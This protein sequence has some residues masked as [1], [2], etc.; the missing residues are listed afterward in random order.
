MT[1][2]LATGDIDVTYGN[3][4]VG[5]DAS[6]DATV[7]YMAEMAKGKFGARSP[8]IRAAAINIINGIDPLN[9]KRIGVPVDNKDYFGMLEAIHNYVRD[10]IR[11]V[12]DVVGQETL[13]YPEETIFNSRAGDCDDMTI[14]EI[15][16]LGAI[17]LRSYPVVIGL[18]PGH[19]SHV[20]LHAEIPEGRHRNAGKTFAADPI[21]REWELG[22]A[23][24]DARVKAKRVYPHLA[25]LGTMND[26]GAYANGPSYFSP[27]DEL[28]AS[29]V[30]GVLKRRITDT[31]SRGGIITTKR[32]TERGDELDAMFSRSQTISPMQAAPAFELYSRGPTTNRAEKVMTSYLHQA[33]ISALRQPASR[34]P[35]I[36]TVQD[37][38]RPVRKGT[39]APTINELKGLADY[40]NDLAGPAVAAS[41]RH[42][43]NGKSDILHRA[44]AAAAY[45]KQRAKKASGRVVNWQQNAGFLFGLGSMEADQRIGAAKAIEQLAHQIAAQAQ[46]IAE[47]CAGDSPARR[48][49]LEQDFGMLD[50]MDCHL[51]VIDSL[52]EAEPSAHP[53]LD[54]QE[55]IDTL[56]VIGQNP[57]FRQ[58]STF[59]ATPPT[60]RRARNPI[61][62]VLPGGAV[63][64][65]QNGKVIYA[66][67]GSD[68]GLAGFGSKIKKRAKKVASA[69]K[70]AVKSVHK[71]VKKVSKA[72]KSIA[73][74]KKFRK[75]ALGVATAGGSLLSRKTVGV[76][77]KLMNRKKSKGGGGEEAATT[78]P[79]GETVFQDA[80]GNV[81]TE[82][83]Y[84]ALMAQANQSPPLIAPDASVT[85]M[86]EYPG[87]T[88]S[89]DYGA[90]DESL[91]MPQ[92]GGSAI[93]DPYAMPA[94]D[95][96]PEDMGPAFE[97]ESATSDYGTPS[98]ESATTTRDVSESGIEPF[99]EED[100]GEYNG[101]ESSYNDEPAGDDATEG[102]MMQEDYGYGD[103][104]GSFEEDF[105]PRTS[106][107]HK[108][109]QRRFMDEANVTTEDLD[110]EEEGG[111]GESYEAEEP[112]IEGLPAAGGG[113]GLLA[114][115]GVGLYLVTRK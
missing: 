70:K 108:R 54:A 80:E 7:Q 84:N 102:S 59:V 65:D 25:G 105:A 83:Q 92:P 2:H 114:L 21:M 99:A 15:G 52:V 88:Q 4:P 37:K 61:Q 100:E 87:S 18:V 72:A 31:G 97:A 5:Q 58:A 39:V 76:A 110:N 22:R 62:G 113:L 9:G 107:R 71:Q 47:A 104:E 17:G 81:I 10:N 109:R 74:N 42:L 26:I 60:E 3:L 11:Y 35:K 34:G 111:E 68:D 32:L 73:K 56:V 95:F 115:L 89:F 1:D 96:G 101:E 69:P 14:L 23:A 27:L 6:V 12:K 8:K 51:G 86:P 30:P 49:I 75:I 64:R 77:K 67:D 63:V 43:V 46:R 79:E 28:E 112:P 82:A 66:D 38:N 24:P 16:L 48:S 50:H 55:K 13:S 20:Y 93:M 91:T 90:G 33:P 53:R 106:R 40:I 94:D 98:E 57:T 36:V 41:R 45:T 85:E 44:A 78:T 19:F 103:E 29:Q